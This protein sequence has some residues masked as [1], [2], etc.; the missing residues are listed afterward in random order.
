MRAAGVRFGCVLADAGYGMSAPFRHALSERGLRMGCRHSAASDGLPRRCGI[1]LSRRRPGSPTAATHPRQQVDLGA[2]RARGRVLA[3]GQLAPRHKRSNVGTLRRCECA[4]RRR[5]EATHPRHGR[6]THARRRGMADRR[7]SRQRRAQILPLEPA[8]RH[9]PQGARQHH[10]GAVDL[11]AGA[12]ATEGRTRSR[13][14]SRD[15]PGMA[16]TVT[17]S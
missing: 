9:A 2:G 14:L 6:P 1:D 3:L 16:S 12:S 11:R 4:G 5:V 7:T 15:D 8:R 13:S 10:Q 17:P